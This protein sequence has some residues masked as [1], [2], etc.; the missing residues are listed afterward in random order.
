MDT[1]LSRRVSSPSFE[2]R[3]LIWAAEWNARL[4]S[5]HESVAMFRHA[6]VRA[7]ARASRPPPTRLPLGPRDDAKRDR[8]RHKP[9][10][11][12]GA[13]TGHLTARQVE[14]AV[15]IA[16]GLTN[17]G[18]ADE[19]VLTPGTV[20]NHVEHILTKLGFRSRAQIAVWAVERGLVA[21]ERPPHDMPA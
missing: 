13:N 6:M 18:I 1:S 8:R 5:Y 14:V 12:P 4:Q 7:R 3:R 17:Q 2:D 15:M 9:R 19:L 20:A 10:P 11:R 16:R 21:S